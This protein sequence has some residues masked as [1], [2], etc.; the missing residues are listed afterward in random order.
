LTDLWLT[1]I[2]FF[3]VVP[4]RVPVP[5]Q[6]PASSLSDEKNGW[7]FGPE[8]AHPNYRSL[9]FLSETDTPNE[10]YSVNYAQNG[11]LA[12]ACDFKFYIYNDDLEECDS[13]RA[14]YPTCAVPFGEEVFYIDEW[15]GGRV[16]AWNRSRNTFKTLFRFSVSDSETS[17]LSVNKQYIVLTLPDEESLTIYDRYTCCVETHGLDFE[18]KDV[19]LHS[20][21]QLVVVSE[22][23]NE[24]INYEVYDFNNL[25]ELWSYNFTGACNVC[26]DDNGYIFVGS[27]KKKVIHVLS[28]SG[29]I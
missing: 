10:C 27:S 8:I 23:E 22:V 11:D 5:T 2:Y 7:Y 28:P 25:I 20:N 1:F 13:V 6:T 26:T 15:N 14:K 29:K 12:V 4:C 18:P 19:H 16:K 24:V 9:R 17:M 21:N 3:S